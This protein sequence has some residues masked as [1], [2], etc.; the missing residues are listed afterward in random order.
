[1]TEHIVHKQFRCPYCG[2]LNTYHYDRGSVPR[3]MRNPHTWDGQPR[4]SFWRGC[5]EIA[6][7]CVECDREYHIDC[8]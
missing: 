7:R 5:N 8:D 4:G 3:R 1:M 6:V 2:Y